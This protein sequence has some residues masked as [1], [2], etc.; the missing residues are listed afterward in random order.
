MGIGYQQTDR[1][2][3]DYDLWFA[4]DGKIA[5]RGPR[6]DLGSRD[7]VCFIGA[8]QTFGRFA[9][10]PYP[11][12]LRSLTGR[13]VW[14]LGFSG[15][16]PQYFLKNDFLMGL[17]ER[18]ETVV[19]QCMSARSITAG[20]FRVGT[21][22]GVL[23][24]VNGP[25][26]GQSHMAQNAYALLRKQY[27]EDVFNEQIGLVQS[28]WIEL[29]TE[30]IGRIPG[31]KILFWLSRVKPGANLT[32][33]NSS[34]GEFPHFVTEGMVRQVASLC[35]SYADATF[36]GTVEHVLR[37]DHTRE[38]VQVFNEK[39]FPKR[40]DKLRCINNYYPTPQMH[41]FAASVLYPVLVRR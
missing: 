1:F 31:K 11:E 27:G 20:C 2:V 37:D 24:F 18:A 40:P 35:D 19:I 21:N 14:N 38:V 15:A 25:L 6:F 26:K 8:A 33:H 30:L 16:G 41:E 29:Y 34:V 5:F 4:D 22:F 17:V 36:E 28:A 23:E 9:E 7:A 13:A 3:V 12:I 32:L 10:R 39:Q